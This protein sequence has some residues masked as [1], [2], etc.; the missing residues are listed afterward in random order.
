[1]NCLYRLEL[2]YSIPLFIY[3]IMMNTDAYNAIKRA[4]FVI[5]LAYAPT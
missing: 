2:Y 3:M 5:F 4:L 1:M